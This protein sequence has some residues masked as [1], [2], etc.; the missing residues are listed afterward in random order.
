V[1]DVAETLLQVDWQV[2]TVVQVAAV[3]IVLAMDQVQATHQLHH[4]VKVTQAVQVPHLLH[5][6]EEGEV[7]PEQ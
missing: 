5:I 4:L 1:A 2:K 7:V 3:R 6:L